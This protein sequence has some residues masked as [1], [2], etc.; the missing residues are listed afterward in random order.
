MVNRKSNIIKK[1]RGWRMTFSSVW[2]LVI[3]VIF[4]LGYDLFYRLGAIKEMKKIY[5]VL[6]DVFTCQREILNELKKK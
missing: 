2:F 4:Y 5:E 3:A 1:L 6:E